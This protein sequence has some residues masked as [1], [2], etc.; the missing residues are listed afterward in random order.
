M[1][2]SRSRWPFLVVIGALALLTIGSLAYALGVNSG[3]N[4]ATPTAERTFTPGQPRLG[5][6]WFGPGWLG[7]DG[8]RLL[9]G[10]VAA[11]I[12]KIDGTKLTLQATNGQTQT[13]DASGATV[14]R[15]GQTISL[16]DLKVGDRITFRESRQ[17]GGTY[18]I[19]SIE[20]V[21]PTASG[22][23]SAVSAGSVTI[24]QAD[25]SSKTLT[26]TSATT[27]TQAGATVSQSAL[28]VGV[29]IS[30]QGTTDSAGNFTATAVTIPPSVVQ[31]TVASKT[32]TTIVVTTTAGKTVTV[33]VSAS[34]KYWVRG[35]SS[36]TLADVAVGYR[37][38]AEGTLNADGSLTATI[39]E[40]ASGGLPRWSDHGFGGLP[41]FPDLPGWDG[42]QAAPT[43]SPSG[44]SI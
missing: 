10:R 11:T 13:L 40:A 25:G 35:V 24:T 17:S 27:Y 3:R 5:S 34:T 31:G 36:P 39:V 32:A 7:R 9:D 16:S 28:V 30:A 2:I 19:T 38:A 42:G 15:A 4:N 12:T 37:I 18:K 6:G 44:A 33:N 14:T 20:V 8:G 21:V 23:V 29:R 1:T 26:L 41:G 22:T 43:P